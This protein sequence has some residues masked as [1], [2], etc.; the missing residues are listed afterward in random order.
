MAITPL[1]IYR[2]NIMD[3][4]KYLGD[5][6]EEALHKVG[7]DK[8]V[9]SVTGKHDCGCSK[10]KRMLNTLHRKVTG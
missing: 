8:V 5:I 3:N 2:I 4:K 6:V 7:V 1:W 10:R 9:K